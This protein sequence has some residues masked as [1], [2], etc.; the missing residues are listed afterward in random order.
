MKWAG[1]LPLP[2]KQIFIISCLV[3]LPMLT[4]A[5]YPFSMFDDQVRYGNMDRTGYFYY[6]MDRTI[7]IRKCFRFCY[8]ENRRYGTPLPLKVS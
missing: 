7:V 4:A 3:G 2:I 1:R 5:D 6:I 8:T